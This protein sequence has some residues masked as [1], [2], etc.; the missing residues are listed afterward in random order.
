[1]MEVLPWVLEY[2]EMEIEFGD[3]GNNLK[4]HLRSCHTRISCSILLRVAEMNETEDKWVGRGSRSTIGEC[5]T[6]LVLWKNS[7]ERR[8]GQVTFKAHY[9]VN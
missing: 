3:A 2:T 8:G 6:V 1:M 9:Q 5:V 4:G 7:N